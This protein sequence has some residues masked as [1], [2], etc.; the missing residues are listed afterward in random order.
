MHFIIRC[1]ENFAIGARG[2][3]R[4]HATAVLAEV[5]IILARIAGYGAI[6]E[7]LV[8]AKIHLVGQ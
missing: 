3:L 6:D 5:A 4:T 1:N 8:N 7:V 2:S